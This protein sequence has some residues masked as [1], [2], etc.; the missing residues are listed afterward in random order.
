[1]CLT[2][3]VSVRGG[4]PSKTRHRVLAAFSTPEAAAGGGAPTVPAHPAEAGRKNARSGYLRLKHAPE[5]DN[6]VRGGK[7]LVFVFWKKSVRRPRPIK[8][9]S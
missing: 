9:F 5:A 8:K 2:S 1:M 3:E 6:D 4:R 7:A